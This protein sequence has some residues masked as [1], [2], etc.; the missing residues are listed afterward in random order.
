[1]KLKELQEFL[2][3]KKLQSALFVTREYKADDTIF[4]LTQTHTYQGA[5]VV[6]AT[7]KPVLYVPGFEYDRIKKV[8]QIKTVS[9]W[10]DKVKTGRKVG[11]NGDVFS[12][13]E[14]SAIEGLKFTD[15]SQKLGELRV[16]KTSKEAKLLKEAA[17]IGC[18]IVNKFIPMLG[19][20]KTEKE[21]AKFLI[22]ETIN[23]DCELS[24]A[25]I[26]ASGANAAIPHHIPS[27]KMSKGFCVID[28]GVKYKGYCS[29]MTRTPFLGKATE[30]DKQHYE[31]L[32]KVQKNAL[33]KLK[34]G[35][36]YGQIDT[37]ARKELGKYGKYFVHRLGHSVGV[38]VHDITPKS[39]NN[40]MQKSMVWTVEPGIYVPGKYGIRIEDTTIITN[41]GNKVITNKTPKE[42]RQISI[43][44]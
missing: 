42:F 16:Q 31:L 41:N 1:M 14:I 9:G 2:R 21:A 29:D 22:K 44:T 27:G 37:E 18:E 25:P 5:L 12:K 13:N 39:M 19:K 23:N 28:F 26:V 20:F 7:G 6:P 17:T 43:T 10:L 4:Y 36:N 32:L 34:P 8:S 11:I 24:F 38:W 35:S 3:R 30:K 33:K 40:I 15:I